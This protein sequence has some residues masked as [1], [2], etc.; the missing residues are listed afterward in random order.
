[1][2]VFTLE[3]SIECPASASRAEIVEGWF[4]SGLG[5]LGD[6]L[7]DRL[8]TQ[9]SLPA[10]GHPVPAHLIGGTMASMVVTPRKG[11]DGPGTIERYSSA[12]LERFKSKFDSDFS[13][14]GLVAHAVTGPWSVSAPYFELRC[15]VI[16]EVPEYMH[17][18]ASISREDFEAGGTA[19]KWLHFA[20][21][22]ADA[23]DPIFG[24]SVSSS[25]DYR[26]GREKELRWFPFETVPSGRSRLRG[27]SWITICSREIVEQLGGIQGLAESEAFYG[28]R[29]T[30]SGGA[31]LQASETYSEYLGH[32]SDRLASVLGSVL[33]A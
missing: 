16:P 32:P 14:I 5:E 20:A 15:Q 3:L 30:V 4:R 8:E 21:R 7:L 26:T 27:Y 17:L 12:A 22:Q 2:E 11:S 23:V 6:G 13:R 19:Q 25:E 1:M 24:H 9:G 31:V 33:F 10:D 28:V 18:V 29:E